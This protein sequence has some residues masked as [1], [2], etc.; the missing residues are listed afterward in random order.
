METPI[1]FSAYRA[2]WLVVMFD[3]PT[4][5]HKDRKVYTKF[6]DALMDDGFQMMQFS[7]YMRFCPSFDNMN[8][9]IKRVEEILPPS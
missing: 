5:T 4:D 3:L 6:R 2:M 7:I 1:L 9:H 8:V